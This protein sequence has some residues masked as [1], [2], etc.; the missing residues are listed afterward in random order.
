[1][2]FD[3]HFRN[4]ASNNWNFGI[5][6]E[7]PGANILDVSYVASKG[8]WIYRS[9]DGNPPDPALVAQL[10][11]ICSSSD[12]N[13]NTTGCVPSQVSST[14]LYLGAEPS[15]GH[16]LPF[17]A[18]AHNALVQAPYQRSVAYSN[19][20]SL[21]VKLTHQLRH[22]IYAQLSYTWSHALDNSSD[23]LVP[24]QNNRT[25][26]RNSRD[27]NQDY[28]NSDNDVR[29]VAVIN[30]IWEV[31]LGRGRG[32]LSNGVMGKVL[33]GM[34]FSGVTSVQTGH[35]FE[36]RCRRDSQRTG[37][38]SWC[39]NVGDPFTTGTNNDPGNNP[40]GNKVYWGNPAA[41]ATPP[42]GRAGTVGRNQ[43]YG[44]GLVNFDLSFAKKMK[45]TERV[46]IEGRVE[47]YNIFNRPHFQQPDNLLG[48]T[49]FGLITATA[50]RP[51]A[52]TSARQMQAAIKVNF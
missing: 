4:S 5:Q 43:Y 16:V 31:P 45:V 30:Y 52:T 18:V 23:P 12:P 35:P 37:I 3:T 40:L 24:G 49:N 2:I 39:D 36:V 27:L 14:N 8:T 21:Q 29:H 9:I 26:P 13:V 44:P 41:F 10:V 17:N 47:G 19:Y 34:Q 11:A 32:Y 46:E 6:R 22:G 28:G 7:L 51:D 48:D 20:N 15:F 1:V 38:A 25:F 42:F 33:E 50:S